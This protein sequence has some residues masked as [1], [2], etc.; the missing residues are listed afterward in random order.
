MAGG[1]LGVPIHAAPGPMAP[2]AG[3]AVFVGEHIKPFMFLRIEGRFHRLDAAIGEIDEELAEGFVADHP[4]DD[5]RLDFPVNSLR[6]NLEHLAGKGDRGA[7]GAVR[8]SARRIKCRLIA[9]R[10]NGPLGKGVVRGGPSLIFALMTR[11]AGGRAGI[12][13]E[14]WGICCT[15]NRRRIWGY[16]RCRAAD[17]PIPWSK[18]QRAGKGEACLLYTSDA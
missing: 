16:G 5:L 9:G 2:V 15:G 18:H 7:L 4:P 6:G 3:L 8:E 14:V 11:L 12:A 1:T 10:V 13:G 17:M